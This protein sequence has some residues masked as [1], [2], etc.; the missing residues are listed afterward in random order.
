MA[1][2]PL[3]FKLSCENC[4]WHQ[5]FSPKSDAMMPNFPSICPKCGHT[6]LK[7]ETLNTP[8]GKMLGRLFG[9]PL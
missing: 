8:L 1:W 6:E 5:T 7:R 4:G 3:P 9:K 2:Q